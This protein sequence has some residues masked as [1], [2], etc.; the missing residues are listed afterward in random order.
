MGVYCPERIWTKSRE[1]DH[2]FDSSCFRS[3]MKSHV[4]WLLEFDYF[5]YT[6]IYFLTTIQIKSTFGDLL[7]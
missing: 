4:H 3:E 1:K 2:V 7:I 5:I 6:Y